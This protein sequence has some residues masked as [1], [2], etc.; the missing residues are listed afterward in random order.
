MNMSAIELKNNKAGVTADHA[1]AYISTIAAI[2]FL[3]GI[4]IYF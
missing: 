4:Y 2:I 1:L 3:V